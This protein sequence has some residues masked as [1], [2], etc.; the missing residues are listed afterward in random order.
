MVAQC[1]GMG[2]GWMELGTGGTEVIVVQP[3]WK[4]LVLE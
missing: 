2:E 3:R 4:A 1:C